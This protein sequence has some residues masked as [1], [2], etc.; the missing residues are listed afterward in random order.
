MK[1]EYDC[2][3]IRCIDCVQYQRVLGCNFCNANKKLIT[4]SSA[5]RFLPCYKKGCDYKMKQTET[6]I[7]YTANDEKPECKFCDHY[8]KKESWFCTDYCGEPNRF[9]Y[10]N[11]TINKVEN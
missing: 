11:R 7:M 6:T 5:L 4:N 3:I 9:C 2:K 1:T 8:G 10:Y